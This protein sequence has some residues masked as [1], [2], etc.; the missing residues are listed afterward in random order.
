MEYLSSTDDVTSGAVVVGVDGS[1]QS[2]LAVNWAATQAALENRT[3]TLVH[4]APLPS[5]H[6]LGLWGLDAREVARTV[7][8][9]AEAILE[10]AAALAEQ[11]DASL[12]IRALALV[13]DPRNVLLRLSA[14][15]SCLVVGSRGR[16]PVRSLL[17]GSVG[18]A[19]ARHARCP[20]VV[21]RPA[22]GEPELGV[23]VGV[24][25]RPETQAVLEFAFDQ[26]AL[27]RLPVTVLH[28]AP[29]SHAALP[30]AYVEIAPSAE[31]MEAHRRMTA[32]MTSGLRERYPDVEVLTEVVAGD[33]D[34]RLSDLGNRSAL[35][36]VGAHARGRGELALT[37]VVERVR[38]PVAVVPAAG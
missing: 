15:A 3:L 1:D 28:V 12:T 17:L 7:T 11:V 30:A 18:T 16:G 19:L 21:L 38:G 13:E 31:E 2:I 23:V 29:T 22:E 36:V 32:E 26:A 5:P 33:P 8:E 25:A 34:D 20:V 14:G 27:R 9:G 4:A 24:D 37:S 6:W 35:L 10:D